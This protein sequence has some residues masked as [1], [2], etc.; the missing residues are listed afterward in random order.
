MSKFR[1]MAALAAAAA[2]VLSACGDDDDSGSSSGGS[3]TTAASGSGGGDGTAFDPSLPPVLIGFHNLEGGVISLPQ[4]REGFEQGM[5]Y[6]NEELG[7]INGHEMKIESCPV[8]ITPESVVNC[9]NL[10]V[11][12]KVVVAAQGVDVVADAMLPI[13][14]AADIAETAF[15]AFS[16]GV[17]DAVGDAFVTMFSNNEGYASS[18]VA[19]KKLGATNVAVLVSDL[20]SGKA[21]YENIVKPAGERLGIK[22]TPFY[23]PQTSTDW[24]SFAQTVLAINP[25]GITIPA[26]QEAECLGA[27]PAFRDAGYDGIFHAGSC[28]EIRKQLDESYLENTVS[29][30]EYYVEEMTS[31]PEKV[32][33][34]FEIYNR[35]MEEG[36]PDIKDTTYGR[37]GFAFAVD[38]A[39]MLRQVP[40]EDVLTASGV[41][42]GLAKAQ[43]VRFFTDLP[44]NC[45]APDFPEASSCGSKVIF[46][47]NIP[48]KKLEVFD[49][50]PVDVKA[51][52]AE[53]E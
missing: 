47:K 38:L 42:A 40:V 48:G 7:G 30:S 14:G 27:L 32:K 34:D 15:F 52:Y 2:L 31:V 10:F 50:A 17:N 25:D 6:V 26:P 24:T 18:V 33:G 1:K 11:E 46:S 23:F 29:H 53:M 20:P 16:Q 39:D 36:A 5:R 4:I 37:L 13:L 12:K 21:A 41:K 28:V 51:A 19:Q 35:Y 44:Y 45:A 3:D 9:G 49:W 43:G 8:D 22:T